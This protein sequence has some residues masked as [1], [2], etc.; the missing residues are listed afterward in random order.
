MSKFRVQ[1]RKDNNGD[2]CD[3]YNDHENLFDAINEANKELDNWDKKEARIGK[4]SAYPI[5]ISGGGETRII[6]SYVWSRKVK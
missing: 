4:L 5:F 6:H 2:W 3:T 1:T